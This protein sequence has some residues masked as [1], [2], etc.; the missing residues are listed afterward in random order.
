VFR[1]GL[2]WPV[3]C[4]EISELIFVS[5]PDAP[6]SMSIEPLQ[7][8]ALCQVLVAAL[9]QFLDQIVAQDFDALG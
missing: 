6:A 8:V 9:C 4:D 3:A 2:D 7:A 1:G 5:L